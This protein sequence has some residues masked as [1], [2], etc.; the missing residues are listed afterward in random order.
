MKAVYIREFGG[1]GNLE[2][3]KVADPAAPIGKQ[4][5]VRVK[6]ASLNRADLLQRRGAYPPP[7]GYSPNIP[8][9]EF[10][11]EVADIGEGVKN[12]S[13]GDRVFGITAGEAQAELLLTDESVL[14]RIPE[15][16]SF[17][18][19]AAVPE[20]FITAHDALFTL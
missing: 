18:E 19:A 17:I 6:A 4:V 7:P 20:V 5:K 16:L 1:P 10:A 14:A 9:M 12:F 2:L 15:N 8:G 13:V 11:G 3:R